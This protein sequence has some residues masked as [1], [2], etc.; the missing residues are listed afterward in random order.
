MHQRLRLTHPAFEVI[1]GEENDQLR[2]IMPVYVHP[3][4][5]SL[6]LLRKWIA[7]ALSAYRGNIP[8]RLPQ[9]ICTRQGL[10]LIP[11]ALTE[12]HDPAVDVDLSGLMNSLLR[13]TGR[14][15]STSFFTCN[16]AWGCGAKH[17]PVQLELHS[18]AVLE[19]SERR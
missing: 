5:L 13:R 15:S 2:R 18:R 7:Q 16:W 11:D 6:T 12:L 4:G 17:A 19:G 1:E 3:N 10:K 14:L 9:E 8:S